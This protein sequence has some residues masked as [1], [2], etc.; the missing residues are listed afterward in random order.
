MKKLQYLLLK[1]KMGF[2]CLW[3]LFRYR[4]E[5]LTTAKVYLCSPFQAP[6]LAEVFYIMDNRNGSCFMTN[7]KYAE[8][9]IETIFSPTCYMMH[10]SKK[11]LVSKPGHQEFF[12][13]PFSFVGMPA[14]MSF[15]KMKQAYKGHN[16]KFLY[17]TVVRL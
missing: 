3:W 8:D 12:M 4:K 1:W 7:H 6:H 11:G 13:A 10:I 16:I 2:K 17:T 15:N 5:E 14:A 9:R